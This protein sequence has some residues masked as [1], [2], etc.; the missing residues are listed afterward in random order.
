MPGVFSAWRSSPYSG[1]LLVLH[2][3][4]LCSVDLVYT[5][6]ILEKH[7]MPTL[8]QS[9]SVESEFSASGLSPHCV[10]SLLFLELRPE[11]GI[12]WGLSSILIEHH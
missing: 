11:H 6:I 4:F 2:P 10:M 5:W 3:N 1:L 9:P 12:D 8:H 7:S